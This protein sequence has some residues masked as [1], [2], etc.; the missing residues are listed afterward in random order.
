MSVNRL[1]ERVDE[2]KEKKIFIPR[3]YNLSKYQYKLY[4]LV[5]CSTQKRV[6]EILTL[7]AHSPYVQLTYSKTL[8]KPIDY[9]IHAEI[10]SQEPGL[11]YSLINYIEDLESEIYYT[12]KNQKIIS[13]YT[14]G[15][16][17]LLT[18]KSEWKWKGLHKFS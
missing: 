16:H 10:Y 3:L 5:K 1:E 17:E 15:I 4:L 8:R 12:T 14:T 6:D 2:L 11:F 7:L 18:E 9:M 13:I